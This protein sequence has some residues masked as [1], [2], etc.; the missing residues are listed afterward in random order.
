M[1]L[2]GNIV[3]AAF[4]ATTCISAEW[5][6][7][8]AK[9]TFRVRDALIEST[10]IFSTKGSSSEKSNYQLI[11]D[12]V[13]NVGFIAVAVNGQE[14][15]NYDVH[16]STGK[17]I[18]EIPNGELKNGKV[19]TVELT[20]IRGNSLVPFPAE[21]FE[22]ERQAILLTVPATIASPYKTE[23]QKISFDIPDLVSGLVRITP[24]SLAQAE[25]GL[26]VFGPWTREEADK[27]GEIKVHFF[28][29]KPL[30]RVNTVKKICDISHWGSSVSV[31][32][33]ISL[34]NGAA[35]LKG[36]FNRIPFLHLK[37]AGPEN[38]PFP[39]FHAL[40]QFEAQLPIDAFNIHYR[41]VIGN[42]STSNAQRKGDHTLVEIRPRFPMMGGWKTEFEL[43]YDAPLAGAVTQL[44]MRDDTSNEYLVSVPL[45][46]SMGKKMHANKMDLEI[47]L[48]AGAGNIKITVD[49]RTVASNYSI[50]HQKGW[51]VGPGLAGKTVISIPVGPIDSVTGNER[52]HVQYTLSS[53]NIFA[54]PLLLSLYL[55]VLF[56]T[57]ILS[58]RIRM[59]ISNPSESKIIDIQNADY[60][61]CKNIEDRFIDLCRANTVLIETVSTESDRGVLEA[62]KE[63]YKDNHSKIVSEI[64]KMCEE[65]SSEKNRVERTI[66]I[67]L[68]LKSQR[69]FAL[70][71]VD[72]ATQGR[73]VLNTA[74]AR[75]IENENEMATLVGRVLT[76]TATPPPSPGGSG[77]ASAGSSISIRS[78]VTEKSTTARKR[79]DNRKK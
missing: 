69:D 51:L 79:T 73:D 61:I 13:E 15:R 36:E 31:K 43:S 30:P 76:G 59:E 6:N 5:I 8:D 48:P 26:I 75:L 63:T 42:V 10:T 62:T 40:M 16:A 66:R 24:A 74:G 4:A 9:Q 18:L 21:I 55:F 77:S 17:S 68:N 71:L 25:N 27:Q 49:G 12:D 57:Y 11:V 19:N 54:A 38:A 34:L 28:Y 7:K 35:S 72:N 65:F 14:I 3:M 58:R 29:N 78:P 67:V 50:S 46:P 23:T 44:L 41:D 60:D 56:G 45:V 39:I 22:L 1:R 53:L 64:E 52:V 2:F 20:V 32:E 47:I 37:Y 33:E 70:Q